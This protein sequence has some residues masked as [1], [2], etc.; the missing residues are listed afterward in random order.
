MQIGRI[1]L[2]VKGEISPLTQEDL[3]RM[4]IWYEQRLVG[5]E[6]NH[7]VAS[8][9]RGKPACWYQDACRSS[10]SAHGRI[11][12][13]Q[14]RF[15]KSRFWRHSVHECQRIPLQD[16][17]LFNL[18]YFSDWWHRRPYIDSRWRPDIFHR[19]LSAANP[20]ADHHDRQWACETTDSGFFTA[21]WFGRTIR[22]YY[23]REKKYGNNHQS[24]A[25]QQAEMEG[26]GRKE[27]TPEIIAS[28]QHGWKSIMADWLLVRQG[29]SRVDPNAVFTALDHAYRGMLEDK[30]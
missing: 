3:E 7:A 14:K 10:K 17:R 23:W 24:S 20:F 9:E 22:L 6:Q 29:Y 4:K 8:Q 25:V 11:A 15:E 12:L 1:H 26:A 5:I 21:A 30:E 2:M 18:A 19:K 27:G 28:C 13:F 16:D